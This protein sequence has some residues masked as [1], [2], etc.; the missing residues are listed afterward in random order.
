MASPLVARS[1][2]LATYRWRSMGSFYLTKKG[3]A[4]LEITMDIRDEHAYKLSKM[5]TE[6]QLN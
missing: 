6:D 1:M 2:D 5:F 4:S 3:Y